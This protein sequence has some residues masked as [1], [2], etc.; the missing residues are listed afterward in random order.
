VIIIHQHMGG[1]CDVIW[2]TN[3]PYRHVFRSV[4]ESFF[5]YD[6]WRRMMGGFSP[7]M[8]FFLPSFFSLLKKVHNYPFFSFDFTIS[9]LIFFIFFLDPFIKVFMLEEFFFLFVIFFLNFNLKCFLLVDQIIFGLT[10]FTS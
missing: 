10:K 4:I 9:L 6:T 2:W 5:L 7:I 3:L 8:V 1:V